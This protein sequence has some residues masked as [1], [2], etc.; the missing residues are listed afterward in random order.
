MKE[1]VAD[2]REGVAGQLTGRCFYSHCFVTA[3]VD[4][5]VEEELVV[6]L[7]V[8]ALEILKQKN[9]LTDKRIQF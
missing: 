9:R 7:E 8:E 5:E 4:K 2:K 6:I 1:E 3:L